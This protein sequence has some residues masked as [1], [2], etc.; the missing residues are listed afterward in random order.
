LIVDDSPDLVQLIT[1]FAAGQGFSIQSASAVPEA[2]AIAKA[3]RP[4][5]ILLDVMI[6]DRDGWDALQAL[7]HDPETRQIPVVVCTV[8][9]E[10]KLALAL[11]AG[12]FIRKPLTRP[13][14]LA[15]L[16]R[17]LGASPPPAAGRRASSG[18]AAEGR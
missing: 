17:S 5:V 9:G 8:L 13:S 16:R 12:D 1:R 7:K 2:L 11:G 4:D 18:A 14:V 15:V 6:P 3:S 10:S